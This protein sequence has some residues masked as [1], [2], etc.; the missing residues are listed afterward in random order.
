MVPSLPPT[1]SF[2]LSNSYA[3]GKQ[4]DG[5]GEGEGCIA[6]ASVCQIQLRVEREVGLER[7]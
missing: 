6:A 3:P 7:G 5:E 1:P 2:I 4:S